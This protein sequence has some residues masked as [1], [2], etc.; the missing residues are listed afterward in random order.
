MRAY[1][2]RIFMYSHSKSVT[3]MVTLVAIMAVAVSV[4]VLAL[5]CWRNPNVGASSM[6]PLTPAVVARVFGDMAPFGSDA[7][8]RTIAAFTVPPDRARQIA[9][10][11]TGEVGM[12]QLLKHPSFVVAGQYLF[13]K[14]QK[15][16]GPM[17]DGILIDGTSGVATPF[18]VPK[19]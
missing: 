17:D 10:G 11:V 6:T 8:Q 14:P 9:L 4:C 2:E 3:G 5:G 18:V 1:N 7:Y 12:W 19:Q 15:F 16:A 13:I